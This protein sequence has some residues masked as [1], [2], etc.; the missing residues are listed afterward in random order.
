MKTGEPKQR[1][2]ERLNAD[3]ERIS[4]QQGLPMMYR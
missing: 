4:P 1:L 2:S 3:M